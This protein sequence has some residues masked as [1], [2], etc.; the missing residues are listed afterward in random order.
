MEFYILLAII[1][2]LV[3][4]LVICFIYFKKVISAISILSES[5]KKANDGLINQISL[6]SKMITQVGN[7]FDIKI[8]NVDKV[9]QENK[10][11]LNELVIKQY[12]NLN[13]IQIDN[14]KKLNSN[15]IKMIQNSNKNIIDTFNKPLNIN[16]L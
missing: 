3:F 1:I 2:L 8:E 13:K 9:L 10:Q 11:E 15:L 14:L 6:N 7:H 16:D 5:L 12:N 4:L